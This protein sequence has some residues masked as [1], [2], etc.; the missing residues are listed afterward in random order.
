[1]S[2]ATPAADLGST[3]GRDTEAVD[4]EDGLDAMVRRLPPRHRGLCELRLPP[5]PDAQRRRR[6]PSA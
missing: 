1:M 3:A 5:R 2:A 4:A 6:W